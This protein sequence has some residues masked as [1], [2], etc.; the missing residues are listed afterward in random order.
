VCSLVAG[1]KMYHFI[2][3]AVVTGTGV[4][5]DTGSVAELP[6]SLVREHREEIDAG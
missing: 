5:E 3:L 2:C 4:N 6:A 1:S